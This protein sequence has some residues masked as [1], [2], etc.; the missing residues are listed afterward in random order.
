VSLRW[1]STPDGSSTISAF[2]QLDQL[3]A[4]PCH[5]ALLTSLRSVS[6][7]QYDTSIVVKRD[8]RRIPLRLD[9]KTAIDANEANHLRAS[10]DGL[11]HFYPVDIYQENITSHEGLLTAFRRVQLLEGF[12]LEDH[13]R[14]GSY[15]LLHVDVRIYWDLLRFL[16][17]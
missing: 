13:Q 5:A 6:Y 9:F 1:S 15:S 14:V 4:N 10:F 12:G 7:Y 17:S 3:L 8:V 16:Y 11:S 2:P